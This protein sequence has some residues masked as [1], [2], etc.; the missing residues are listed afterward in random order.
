MVKIVKF[1]G[2]VLLGESL[3]NWTWF[4]VG[5]VGDLYFPQDEEDLIGLLKG[6]GDAVGVTVLGAGANTLVREGGIEGKVVRLRGRFCFTEIERR[7]KG[8]VTIRVGSGT[9]HMR[10]ALFAMEHGVSGLEFLRTIPGTI[11]GGV[12]M[13]AGA[14]GR[15]VEDIFVGAR[16]VSRGGEGIWLEKE[17]VGFGYRYTAIPEG[18][19]ITEVVVRGMEGERQEIVGLMEKLLKERQRTQPKPKN[20]GGSTFKN[21][22]EAEKAWQVIEEAGC[23]G[24]R[25]GGAMVSRD[26][27]N[28]IINLGHGTATDIENLGEM[29][30]KRV[31]D[32]QG[33]KLQWEIHIKGAPPHD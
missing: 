31:Y 13:N 22:S 19:V 5:G 26:H 32:T 17:E 24:L 25:C 10:L 4:R 20:T 9:P 14:Y 23:C 29:I 7:E 18:V 2:K 21:P 3:K 16:G 11:G 27:C 30:R 1:R 6:W 33:I 12:I 15:C 28:F 8:T